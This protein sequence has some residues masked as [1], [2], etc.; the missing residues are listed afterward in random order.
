[1]AFALRF[2]VAALLTAAL[3]A[4][5]DEAGRRRAG[6]AES[7]SEW[8]SAYERGMAPLGP[9]ARDA[10]LQPGYA[11][12]AR[13]HDLLSGRDLG[14][15]THQDALAKLLLYAERES[16]EAVGMAVLQLAAIG[17]ERGLDDRTA[18]VLRD[19]GHWSLMRMDSQALWFRL[20]RTASGERLPVLSAGRGASE[21]SAALR[22]AAL[23]VLGQKGAP[24][25]RSTI[26]GAMADLD[27]RV[28]LAAVEAVDLQRRPESL[29]VLV[30]GMATER[31]PV[32]SQALVRALRAVL[33]QHGAQLPATERERAVRAAMRRFGEAGWR[34]DMDLLDFV[35]DFPDREAVPALIGILE[36]AAEPDALVEA[37]NKQASPLLRARAH[38]CLR[39]LTGALLPADDPDAWRRFW[40]AEHDRIETPE[41]LP[42]KRVAVSTQSSF[43]GV[44]VT[45]REV[46]F[47]LDAS[48]SMDEQVAGTAV[49][50]DRR[51]SDPRLPTRL[52]M[53]KEQVITAVQAMPKESRYRV[54]AFA[55]DLKFR[56]RKPVQPGR[57]S[58]R[59]LVE[60]LTMVAADGGTNLHAALCEALQFEG[61]RYGEEAKC[62]VDEVFLLSDGLPTEGD[63]RD[64]DEI[65][66]IVRQANR[67][68]HVRIHTVFTGTGSGAD[69]LRQ[70]AEQ[71]DGVF[72]QR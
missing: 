24:V 27:P 36:R 40:A 8:V 66:E 23:R 56:S 25:F 58:T 60:M 44:P 39:G 14:S 48:G 57:E 2:L 68:L 63:V 15:L 30:R 65:L 32:V 55:K 3:L 72:V 35:E 33:L 17:F 7:I 6:L 31:H 67:Y 70:L 18:V 29:S 53:A 19:M 59:A 64:P 16:D 11:R 21:V 42:H 51:R 9:L 4:Q 47:L 1:M 69:F 12:V 50:A 37:V 49:D 34:T 52:R 26:E 71:N 43:F 10:G 13:R 61:L 54:L 46:V 38:E 28:R 5:A 41:R 20:M 45:G 22:V 62:E